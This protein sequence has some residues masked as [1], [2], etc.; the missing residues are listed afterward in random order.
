MSKST[1][2]KEPSETA[3]LAE[4]RAYV[5][6]RLERVIALREADVKVLRELISQVGAA[7][8]Y[9][10][11]EFMHKAERDR[12]LRFSLA[13]DSAG[14]SFID[15]EGTVVPIPH[16]REDDIADLD[17]FLAYHLTK[18]AIRRNQETIRRNQEA[19]RSR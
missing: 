1:N 19:R 10:I 7:S 17:A 14:F 2:G 8:P 11:E 15:A 3:N 6:R 4:A 13:F 12:T 9:L 5:K 16:P 18:E